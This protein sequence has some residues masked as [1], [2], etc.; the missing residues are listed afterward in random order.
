MAQFVLRNRESQCSLALNHLE[1]CVIGTPC[2]AFNG[3]ACHWQGC[4]P[5]H[6]GLCQPAAV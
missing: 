2:H 3:M 4:W 5:Y 1:C 6:G